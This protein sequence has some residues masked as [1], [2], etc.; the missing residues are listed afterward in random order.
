MELNAEPMAWTP[1]CF[2]RAVPSGA[3]VEERGYLYRG[4]ALK[5]HGWAM[6]RSR[7]RWTLIHIGSGSAVMCFVGSVSTVM[8]VAG[9]IAECTDWTLFDLPDGWKQTDPELPAKVKAIC[10]AHPEAC[11]ELESDGRQVSA[12]DARAVIEAREMA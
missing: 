1:A 5:H 10:E 3:P 8:P 9:E 6:P 4:L 12:E 11:P 7:T 2:F